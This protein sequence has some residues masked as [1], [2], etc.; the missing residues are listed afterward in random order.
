MPNDNH[1]KW[2]IIQYKAF[3]RRIA[4][5][6]ELFRQNGIEPIL[7]K[8][9]AAARNYPNAFERVFTD[10]DLA[11]A[12][13]DYRRALV[14]ASENNLYLDI[15]KE[16]RH[17]DSVDWMKLSASSLTVSIEDCEIRIL[18]P[19]DHL[20]V[21]CVHWLNDGG[22]DKEKL[23]D[24]YYAVENRASNF[25]WEKCLDAAGEKRKKWVIC[26]L[27][28]AEIY[29]GLDLSETPLAGYTKNIPGWLIEAVEKEWS[30][31]IRL[32]PLETCLRDRKELFEQLK[33]RMPPNPLQASIETGSEFDESSR[34][35]A[36]IRSV[37]LRLKLSARRISR[38]RRSGRS[39][40]SEGN[41]EINQ[42]NNNSVEQYK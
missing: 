19:E 36:Q 2:K 39:G 4:S 23:F 7:I 15:H 1:V 40:R 37:F 31:N 11:V 27:G 5:A 12:E 22:V 8:G 21:L 9:W 33:I 32:K 24:I 16:L 6:F 34:I 38:N 17:L 10:I 28:L 35:S 3:E 18:C 29:L 14:L 42:S 41:R 20:R 26:A 30:R 13:K 25:N